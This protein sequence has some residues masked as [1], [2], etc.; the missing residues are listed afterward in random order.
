MATMTI[1]SMKVFHILI[2]LL[3]VY[4]AQAQNNIT[5]YEFW[6]DDDY[7][8]K[9][10]AEVA[11]AEEIVLDDFLDLSELSSGFHTFFIRFKDSG[12]NWSSAIK[13][14]FFK[15]GNNDFETNLVTAYRYWFDSDFQ[16]I[17]NVDL[18]V[19]VE[20]SEINILIEIPSENTEM[21]NI[22]FKDVGNLWSSVYTRIFIP[23]ADFDVFNVVNTFTLMNKTTFGTSYEW[24]FGDDSPVDTTINPTHDYQQ[25]G[26]Y[27]ICLIAKNKLGADTLCKT[28]GVNG[29][30]EVVSNKAGNSGDATVLIY[31][32][33]LK[34]GCKVWLE[35]DGAKYLDGTEVR[36]ARLDALEARFDLYDKELGIYDLIVE[37][38]DGTKL[39]LDQ[40]FEIEYGTLPEPYVSFNGGTRILFGRWQTYTIDFGNT[41]N[42]DAL[43]VPLY[44]L[45]T[46]VDGLEIEFQNLNIHFSEKWKDN[47]FYDDVKQEPDYIEHDGFFDGNEKIRL[48]TFY[49]PVIPAGFSGQVKVR[50][51][52]NVSF[53]AY[54]WLHEPMFE[55]EPGGIIVK[56]DLILSEKVDKKTAACL[57]AVM[58]QCLK[59]GIADIV[60]YAIPG[61]GC[62]NSLLNLT[63][64][65]AGYISPEPTNPEYNRPKS[66]SESFWDW[67]NTVKDWTL[68]IA[69]CATDVLPIKQAIG[70][71]IAA[72]SVANNIY[73]GI[74]AGREC[75]KKY[76]NGM[77]SVAAVSSFDPNEISGPG[78]YTEKKYVKI[79]GFA[80]TIFFEN[81][82]DATAP[83]QEV[84]IRDTLDNEKFDFST[85]SFGQFSFGGNSYYTLPGLKEFTLDIKLEE[86]TGNI[87]RVNG[88]FDTLAGVAYWQFITLD[89]ATMALTEDPMGGFL[90]PNMNSPEGEGSV[91]YKLNI[92]NILQNDE[93]IKAKAH[94]IFDLNEPIITNEYSNSL[95]YAPPQSQIK[96]I[97]TTGE[98]NKYRLG[99]E[100]SDNE[101]GIMYYVIYISEDDDEFLPVYNTRAD[102]LIFYSRGR[103]NIQ[104]LL[105]CCG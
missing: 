17:V 4:S 84:V 36:L 66:W 63:M 71:A 76:K 52:T 105:R 82:K 16:N 23:E 102:N 87:V 92:K 100:G 59:D 3:L 64:D 53:R 54:T 26:V 81:K 89:P 7:P 35:K 19:P 41:G 83:A 29:L 44:F 40:S 93:E 77:K 9:T 48:Y 88:K 67:G 21:F 10:T 31:G 60:N 68:T 6:L 95:D 5:G 55:I 98:E 57:R 18:H 1:N 25:P 15:M 85:F 79:D 50:I 30:R 86:S 73:G 97:Y 45:I 61:V 8:N 47:E 56:K 65:P 42:T 39:R 28:I 74:S 90:P 37:L 51:K 99:I 58:A 96:G 22:Q 94:I 20:Q 72:I 46:M 11:P 27:D 70:T 78:G 33:G 24:D 34:D 91:S 69:S 62:A 12:G 49:I 75:Y 13:S 104:V 103:Y 2:F 80:Y 38:P 14:V 32:G 101:S 43:G